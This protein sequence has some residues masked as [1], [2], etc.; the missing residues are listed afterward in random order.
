MLANWGIAIGIGIIPSLVWLWFYL[1]EDR[2][3]PEPLIVVVYAF[4]LGALGTFL[5]LAVQMLLK[6]YEDNEQPK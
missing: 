1:R 5:V 4:F 3:H 6:D 2:K